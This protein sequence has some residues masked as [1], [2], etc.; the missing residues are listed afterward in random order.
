MIQKIRTSKFS[1]VIA[2]YLAIQLILQ[3]TQASN[4]WALTSGPSQPEF[5]SF[6]P[7]GTSDMVNLASG[8][9]NYNIPIMDVGGYPLNLAYDSGV[10]MDQEASWVG[11]GWNLNVGQI[12]RQVRG[13][14]DDFKGDEMKYEENLK[15]NVTVG[16][17]AAVDPQIF[18]FETPDNIKSLI[19]ASI[20]VNLQYN[21]YT[22]LSFSPSLGLSF[23]L[24]DNVSVGINVQT[25]ATEGVSV[26]PSIGGSK[27]LD[28]IYK[29]IDG[30]L[31]AGI[32]YNSNRGLTSFSLN[33]SLAKE[34]KVGERPVAGGGSNSGLE[35]VNSRF[36]LGGTGLVSF[37]NTT[38]TPRKRTAL[39]TISGTASLS[40]GPSV[41][42]FDA[43]AEISAMGTVQQIKSPE[44]NEKAY[45]Y[46]FT[47]HAT[48]D[49]ILDYNREKDAVISKSTLV[50]PTANYT[51]D[52]Y[53]VNGQ[54]ITGMFRPFRS[55]VGQIN[56]ELVEDESDSFQLGV[57]V[58]TTSSVHVGVNLTAA[59]TYSRTG[60]WNTTALVNFKQARE[61]IRNTST[62]PNGESPDYEP[63]YFKY[64]GEPRVDK[65][66]QLF[67]DLGDYSPIAL[68]IPGPK[69][70]LNEFLK[71]SFN[72]QAENQFRV[73]RYQ[74]NGVPFYPTEVDSD[75]PDQ[76][77]LPPIS[78]KFKRQFR[79]V[80]NQNV[81]K[82]T[83]AEIRNLYPGHN[84]VNEKAK[85]H[86]TAEIQILKGDGATYVFG[87]TAYNLE[88]QEVTFATRNF[89][90]CAT[91]IVRYD[92]DENSKSN[93]S[94]IDEFF[95]SVKTPEYAHTYLLSS[96]LSS[97]YEDITGNG[98]T[99]DD[100]GGYTLFEYNT[101]TEL[102][103]KLRKENG[104]EEI[105]E[106]L[107]Y[108]WRIPY[109][110]RPME[111]A[112]DAGLNTHP[113][114]QKANYIYGRKEIKYIDRITTKTHVALFDLTSRDDG[115]GTRDSNGG[116][117]ENE[118]LG[119]EQYKIERI[120]LYSKPEAEAALILDDDPGNDKFITPIKTAHFIYDYSLCPGV[121]NHRDFEV[122]A[123]NNLGKLTLKKVYFTY[124][125]SDMGKFT[126][127]TFNYDTFNPPYNLKS[128]DIWGN[129]KPNTD[130]GCGTQDPITAPEF[131]FV[132]QED[133]AQQ[134]RYASAWSLSSIDLPSGGKIELTYE[135]DDYQYV[136]NRNAMQMFKVV[137]A[138]KDSS[139]S[140]PE[141]EQNNKL[142][143]GL[144]LQRNDDGSFSDEARYLYIKLPDEQALIT[145]EEFKAKY[146]KN[147]LD[148]PIY[149]RFL[150][151]MTKRGAVSKSSKDY[152]YVTGYFEIDESG[153]DRE[154]TIFGG[155]N[156][157]PVYAAIP[158]KFWDMEGVLFGLAKPKVNPI[159]LA[160]WYFG[161]RHLNGYVYGLN[162]DAGT[163]NIADIAKEIIS[164][165]GAIS[166]I[167]KGPNAKLRQLNYL[168]G[169]KFI[170]EKSWIRLSTP[171]EYKMGGGSRVKK[172]VM[173]DQWHRM[174]G[175]PEGDER[176]DKEYGQTY[177]YT[178]KDGSSS[179][180]ATYEPN[181]SKENPFVEPFYN[182]DK[183]DRLVAP[184]EVSYIEKPFGE[185]FF[186]SATVTYSRVTVQNLERDQE[187][188][189]R[190]ATGKVVTEHYTSKDFPTRVDHTVLDSP[191]NYATNQGEFLRNLVK[192]LLG[193]PV[194]IKSEYALS[195]GFV[196]H[197]NDMNGKVR[198]QKVF[199]EPDENEPET[200]SENEKLLVSS[201]EYEYS[202]DENDKS[203][204]DN[205]LP[206]IDRKGEVTTNLHIGV[207][208]DVVTDF[209]ESYSRAET[210]GVKLNVVTLFIGPFPVIVPTAPPSLSKIEN[211]AHSVITTKVIHTTAQLR[212]KIA[213][214]LGSQVSTI[215]E[216]WD[217]ETGQVLLT[218]TVNEFNDAYYNFN[219]PAYWAYPGMGQASKNSGFTGTL[220]KS[221]EVFTLVGGNAQDYLHPG[222][223]LL[224]SN[225]ESE[226]I[227]LWV[228]GFSGNNV[229]LMDRESASGDNL[230]IQE[231]VEFKVVRSGYRNQHMA[232]MASVTLMKNP[233]KNGDSYTDFL[234]TSLIQQATTNEE[235]NLRIVNASAVEYDDLW[236]CQCEGPF[237]VLP[238][239]VTS[240]E[241]LAAIPL[242]S[243]GFN[244]FLY[245]VKGEWRAK[246]SFAYLT[247]RTEA[248]NAISDKINTR[249][250]G[251]FKEFEPFYS[252]N[253]GIWERTVTEQHIEEEQKWT[254]AS[255]V[256]QYSPFGV[257]LENR[258]A[259]NRHS[260]AQYGYAYTLPTAVASN[261]KYQDMGVDNFEDYDYS[262]IN[263]LN[264]HFNFQETLDGNQGDNAFISDARSHTGRNSLVLRKGDEVYLERQLL[265]EPP[266][267]NDADIDGVSDTFDNCRFTW[268]PL[269][270]LDYD[271]DGVGDACD[272]DFYPV[273]TD[274]VITQNDHTG[275]DYQPAGEPGNRL[276]YCQGVQSRFIVRGKPHA[277][278]PYRIEI[279]RDYQAGE[280]IINWAVL[281]DREIVMDI[282]SPREY[283]GEITL[284]ASGTKLIAFD[285]GG[286]NKTRKNGQS[287]YTI[288]AEFKLINRVTGNP[289]ENGPYP[290]IYID[291]KVDSHKCQN[292]KNEGV[293]IDYNNYVPQT[294]RK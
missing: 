212:K 216:A 148:K 179:G 214:D 253:E 91:G 97:D 180:V 37:E 56:D 150:M 205:K 158:M 246:R 101:Q 30:N 12:N 258:D 19:P 151:N 196:V 195:Q 203:R 18:G 28:N 146:L 191:N 193:A 75:N 274:A 284:D 95:S 156:N 40:V 159:S 147:Q 59:P 105:Q 240:S 289:L 213:T 73:K 90:D 287:A 53:S 241:E 107:L 27:T 265:G 201:V 52:L 225:D 140:D 127:Y 292:T 270:Q 26:S 170:P 133:R 33:A 89:G 190:H 184:K 57:E 32:S 65:D 11:L 232:N 234:N 84:R 160:S 227:R 129:Y 41:W 108:N 61:D 189:H 172:L 77:A 60:I 215:N 144:S 260:S 210:N 25:S 5:N 45:G 39:R 220:Q 288:A 63:V 267:D 177:E 67:N 7:I 275:F 55:Q 120:R 46:E 134:D 176:Y 222:D 112:Y 223:E 286:R 123:S 145:P 261:S 142:Y 17:E 124:R 47:G 168:N 50:L 130:G 9:F 149:F 138:G 254:F 122:D 115:L 85:D 206:T 187:D 277:V 219:F 238:K 14:P 114:D 153:N 211:V 44:R 69:N 132:Q 221:G 104:E 49:D 93:G 164:S 143:T 228:I 251:Y 249:K 273:L 36:D 293:F 54:G 96:V 230:N 139:S 29:G 194:N 71:K 66:Y 174:V 106:E 109:G 169:Q 217:A 272:D 88:K 34:F 231:T 83:T 51:Y 74:D 100:L 255:E 20:G 42:G 113:N 167:F 245:N 13:I 128:Y 182:N 86:H 121:P 23:G 198:M 6:T 294:P 2:S 103:N 276:E 92:A 166:D 266:M 208:Y 192:G 199:G 185:Q 31:N 110:E 98:P 188:I 283:V 43:E 285:V 131:P 229:R 141:G 62:G 244:P 16:V 8:N 70:A 183:G 291:V 282:N 4:L 76:S 24:S 200:D 72:K 162:R 137:G 117:P 81:Q 175:A 279:K 136:Q 152:D 161:R 257:E 242:E 116:L 186:P 10:T 264:G 15:D 79:E 135:T 48:T 94:G 80:R 233:I 22:G 243:L 226:P 269:P 58:E 262:M 21:N 235:D 250:E 236:N 197:T 237:S 78:K 3:M 290:D 207:D 35:D 224:V 278:V 38:V 271:G 171:K 154:I 155:G 165:F 99:D 247:E 126:P 119:Q 118:Q 248:S 259:L 280:R 218:R 102:F 64:I 202:V 87:E 204:L 268:N 68:E 157:Q 82:F 1:K 239:S 209:R 252:L 125:G 181:M 163:Q 173:K 178:L 281:V 111:A 263:T 256:T